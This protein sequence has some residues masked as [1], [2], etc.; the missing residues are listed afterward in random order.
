M[1][2]DTKDNEPKVEKLKGLKSIED[3]VHP[4][5]EDGNSKVI[6]IQQKR[7]EK[8]SK[9]GSTSKYDFK[10]EDTE[11]NLKV[12]VYGNG[13]LFTYVHLM[14]QETP[15]G[16]ITVICKHGEVLIQLTRFEKFLN[17]LGGKIKVEDKLD[18]E[19]PKF[20]EATLKS[21]EHQKEINDRQRRIQESLES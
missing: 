4:I 1:N 3:Y 13:I 18:R 12:D 6:S 7:K 17:M 5:D 16:T 21:L 2:D 10:H 9:E 14:T 20:K 8:K 15:F 19:L 11:Y